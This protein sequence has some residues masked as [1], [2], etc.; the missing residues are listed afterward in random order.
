MKAFPLMVNRS[1]RW[2]DWDTDPVALEIQE[3]KEMDFDLRLTGFDPPVI[4]DIACCAAMRLPK[5]PYGICW[6]S[7][8][9]SDGD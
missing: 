4:D 6:G 7:Q 3:L 2:A 8:P 5:M 9:S 1:V